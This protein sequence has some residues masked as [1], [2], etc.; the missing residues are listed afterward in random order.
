M[1]GIVIRHLSHAGH[2]EY[3]SGT[4]NR[5]EPIFSTNVEDARFFTPTLAQKCLHLCAFNNIEAEAVGYRDDMRVAV[6]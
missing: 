3:Y 4:D 2:W 6:V 1:S 5:G